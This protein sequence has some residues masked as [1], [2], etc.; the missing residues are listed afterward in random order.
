VEQVQS[1][2]QPTSYFRIIKPA[3]VIIKPIEWLWDR[4]IVRGKLNSLAGFPGLGKT[5]ILCDVIARLSR[6]G[7]LP[8]EPEGVTRD[9]VKNWYLTNEDDADD[10]IVPMLEAANY[11]PDHVRLTEE[12]AVLDARGVDEMRKVIKREGFGLVVIDSMT[13]WLPD[14]VDND[15]MG[16]MSAFMKPFRMVAKETGCSIL[17]VR[18]WAKSATKAKKASAAIGSTAQTAMIRCEMAVIKTANGMVLERT[19]GNLAPPNPLD[20]K[21]VGKGSDSPGFVKWLGVSKITEA[22]VAQATVLLGE[23]LR[24]G[25]KQTKVIQVRAAEKGIVWTAMDSA[26]DKLGAKAIQLPG[27]SQGEGWHW[28]LPEPGIIPPS[29]DT[30]MMMPE[31]GVV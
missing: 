6:G 31:N 12:D 16:P 28:R 8:D 10:T 3:R 26:K 30:E 13:S 15:K 17:F 4:R 27:F 1:N 21:I 20:Y 24:D 11:D 2:N 7:M 23:L 9:P 18:H 14:G 29:D 25:P 22:M 5:T 19:K